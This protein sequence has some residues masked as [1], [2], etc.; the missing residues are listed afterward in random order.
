[1]CV[2]DLGD[3]GRIQ[4]LSSMHSKLARQRQSMSYGDVDD[5]LFFR[6]YVQ[7]GTF[8]FLCF[9]SDVSHLEMYIYN[10]YT[11]LIYK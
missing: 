5:T 7:V 10:I 8:P 4:H 6:E 9:F 1:M 11:Y 3:E 2:C